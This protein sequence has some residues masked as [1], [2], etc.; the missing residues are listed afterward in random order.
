M[1][2]AE[3]LAR[4]GYLGFSPFFLF[5]VVSSL[6]CINSDMTKMLKWIGDRYKHTLPS[7]PDR[8]D[9]VWLNPI[10]WTDNRT[11]CDYVA[12]DIHSPTDLVHI[13]RPL[14]DVSDLVPANIKVHFLVRRSPCSEYDN[15]QGIVASSPSNINI[16]MNE[17]Q[18]S[19]IVL[20]LPL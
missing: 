2:V 7:L 16:V 12:L 5:P 9:G 10:G 17:R 20:V 1:R 4:E 3:R 11:G 6:G 8:M 15:A 19:E 13:D 14:G 18:R